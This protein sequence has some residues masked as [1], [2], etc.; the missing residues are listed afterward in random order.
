MLPFST[1]Q[2]Y[3]KIL[4]VLDSCET[5]PQLRN[6]SRWGY[7]VLRKAKGGIE[8]LIAFGQLVR[9]KHEKLTNLRIVE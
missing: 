4:Q 9:Y 3:P 2:V 8:H 5:L 7:C 6:A 1:A